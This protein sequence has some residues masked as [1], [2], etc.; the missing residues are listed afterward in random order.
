MSHVIIDS[1]RF[2]KNDN[3]FKN[4]TCSAKKCKWHRPRALCGHDFLQHDDEGKCIFYSTV[5]E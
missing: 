1:E 2:V 3:Q 4:M 5:K